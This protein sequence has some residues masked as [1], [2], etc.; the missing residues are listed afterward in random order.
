MSSLYIPLHQLEL[1]GE[2]LSAVV[3]ESALNV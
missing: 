3:C 1:L 2:D